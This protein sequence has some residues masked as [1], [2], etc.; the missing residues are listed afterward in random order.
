M[1]PEAV[2]PGRDNAK[3]AA[4]F[5]W[6]GGG[7]L[8]YLNHSAFFGHALAHSKHRMHSVP[9]LR[10]RELSVMSTYM[11]QT[12]WHLPQETHLLWSHLTRS[13]EK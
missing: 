9:F 6:K 4:L 3:N 7:V 13:S 5:D 8:L 12:F 1:K 10:L 2:C 11:G